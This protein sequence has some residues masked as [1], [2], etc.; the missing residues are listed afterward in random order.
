[1]TQTKDKRGLDLYGKDL[2]HQQL[3]DGYETHDAYAKQGDTRVIKVL[4]FPVHVKAPSPMFPDAEVVKEIVFTRGQTVSV[5]QLGLIALEKGERLGAFFTDAELA[6]GVPG[7]PAQPVKVSSAELDTEASLSEMGAPEL[8]LW[9]QGPDGGKSPT[10]P[11][12]LEQVG[13]DKDLAKRMIDAENTRDPDDPRV[14]L[15]AALTKVAE[16]EQ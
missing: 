3:K 7:L 13:D 9:L 10:I 1:M 6:A 5:E 12:I 16:S 11:E 2:T 8:V 15:I 4:Q 14:S